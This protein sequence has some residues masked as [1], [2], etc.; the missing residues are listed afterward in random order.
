[1]SILNSCLKKQ[2][3]VFSSDTARLHTG[4]F[5]GHIHFLPSV[6]QKAL[7]GRTE[8]LESKILAQIPIKFWQNT[9]V[10]LGSMI[11]LSF[12]FNSQNQYVLPWRDQCQLDRAAIGMMLLIHPMPRGC[13]LNLRCGGHFKMAPNKPWFSGSSPIIKWPCCSSHRNEVCCP[14]P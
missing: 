6:H 7:V 1:M 4:S 8:N 11:C 9:N 10:N 12:F 5:T 13:Q 2:K 14:T 3:A